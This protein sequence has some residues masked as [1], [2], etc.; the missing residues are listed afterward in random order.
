MKEPFFGYLSWPSGKINFGWNPRECAIRDLKEETDLVAHDMVLRAIEHIKTFENGNL[1]HHHL[2]WLYETRDFVGELKESTHK[3]R[4]KFM[5]LEEYKKAKR[6]PGEWL[7][8]KVWE[9]DGMFV[10]D[11][12]R[13]MKDGVFTDYRL[14]SSSEY[15]Q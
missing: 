3:A 11:V 13:H 14:V 6:F 10:I 9:N 7:L 1:L 12:E 5:R 4:N 8:D 2:I 15:K